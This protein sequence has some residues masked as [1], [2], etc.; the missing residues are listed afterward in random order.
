MNFFSVF[1]IFPLVFLV[2][3]FLVFFMKSLRRVLLFSCFVLGGSLLFTMFRFS[4]QEVSAH[5]LMK[6]SEFSAYGLILIFFLSTVF[7]LFNFLQNKGTHLEVFSVFFILLGSFFLLTSENL[8][9]A[10]LGM[11]IISVSLYL[12]VADIPKEALKYLF[13]SSFA[14]A[15][16][17]FGLTYI[18]A[19]NNT[20]SLEKIASENLKTQIGSVLFSA[21]FLFKLGIPPFHFW[22]KGIYD[23]LSARKLAFFASVPKTAF[24]FFLLKIS[25]WQGISQSL[26]VSGIAALLWGSLSALQEQKINTLFGFASIVQTGYLILTFFQPDKGVSLFF[27]SVYI[28]I[29][30]L[31]FCLNAYEKL[32][33][34]SEISLHPLNKFSYVLFLLNLIGLP[35]SAGFIAKIYLLGNLWQAKELLLFGSVILGTILSFGYYGKILLSIFKDKKQRNVTSNIYYLLFLF[36]IPSLLLGIFGFSNII[37]FLNFAT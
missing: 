12:F 8:L 1:V 37:K 9:M 15:I 23:N 31:V 21:S 27:F 24:F 33:N 29:I 13:F 2:S 22:I 16:S 5:S 30:F 4:E 6:F 17:V 32:Q 11:E 26:Y 28:G 25:A 20:F 34:V 35:V 14:T 7:F 10:L 18:F 19:G 36:V 3:S